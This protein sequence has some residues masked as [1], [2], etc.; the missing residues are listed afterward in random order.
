MGKVVRFSAFSEYVKEL[1]QPIS[2]T[3][4]DANVIIALSYTPKKYHTRTLDFLNKEIYS[5]GINCY[6]TVNT[7]LEFLEFH[8][9]LLM[10][11]GLRDSID[12][13]STLDLPNKKKQ[14]I[15]AQST[16]LA[17]REKNNKVDPI[18]YDREIKRI[19]EGFYESGTAGKNLWKALCEAFLVG[20][21]QRE[22]VNMN[23]LKVDYLSPHEESQKTF[24]R[25]GLKWEDAIGICS[26]T[27][28]GFSDSM[29]LNAL[30]STTFPFAVSLDSDI[31]FAVLSNSSMKDVV[32][33]DG[34]I[35]EN[36][37]LSKIV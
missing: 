11:E 20:R 10:T 28:A 37:A 1:N 15:R 26:E 12:A 34:L 30:E 33:P 24:F 2:G 18:F 35:D 16:I 8:R 7:T 3:I 27:C 9:R 17:N 36:E 14:L 25:R 32:M 31:A 29:I 5:R 6:T 4:L 23:N 21:L 19:R 13:S 22:Y